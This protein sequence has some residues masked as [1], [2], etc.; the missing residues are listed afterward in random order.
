MPNNEPQWGYLMNVTPTNELLNLA[1]W[2][3]EFLAEEADPVRYALAQVCPE[4]GEGDSFIFRTR[5]HT[6]TNYEHDDYE[7]MALEDDAEPPLGG[8]YS[9]LY[10]QLTQYLRVRFVC[11][12]VFALR[13]DC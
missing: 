11:L 6:P 10:V 8:L 1:L 3:S 5:S 9:R 4:E 7:P 13:D 2:I 12:L